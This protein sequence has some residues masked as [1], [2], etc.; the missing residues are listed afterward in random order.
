MNYNE[1]RKKSVGKETEMRKKMELAKDVKTTVISMLKELQKKKH[2]EQRNGNIKIL[3]DTSR[4]KNTISEIKILWID[5]FPLSPLS[6][7]TLICKVKGI[8]IIA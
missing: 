6:N 1:E 4:N 3:K 5:P 8:K 2:D 7:K